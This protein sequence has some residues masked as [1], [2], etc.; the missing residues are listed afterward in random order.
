MPEVVNANAE[1]G[2]SIGEGEREG[3]GRGRDAKKEAVKRRRGEST[4]YEERERQLC[5][6]R[7][8][9]QGSSHCKQ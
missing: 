1:V 2:R 4:V 8:C 6:V 5:A 9:S 3:D 7:Q